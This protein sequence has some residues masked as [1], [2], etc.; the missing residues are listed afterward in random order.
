MTDPCS[1]RD[2]IAHFQ[3]DII[4]NTAAY[5][6]VNQAEQDT[7]RA[8]S[9]NYEGVQHLAQ[10]CAQ[11][12][13]P[14]IH[15]STDYVF[16]GTQTIPYHENSSPHP[17]NFYGQSKWLGEQAVRDYCTHHIILRISSVFSEYGHNFLKTIL[18][19]AQKKNELCIVAD[20]ISCPTYA[21]DIASTL[22]SMIKQ[23]LV[24]G[25]YHYCSHEPVSWYQFAI[26]IDY[27]SD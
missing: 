9:I 26:A 20:Q 13:T 23:P 25:T 1:I 15:L 5:T 6:A 22:F 12:N 11:T 7:K 24:W 16:A 21:G 3:P 10:R 27:C 4:I 18:R 19:L 14:L 17:I 2:A 8:L